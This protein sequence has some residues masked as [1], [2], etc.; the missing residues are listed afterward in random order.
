MSSKESTALIP[1][2]AL[3]VR[4]AGTSGDSAGSCICWSLLPYCNYVTFLPVDRLASRGREHEEGY[5]LCSL[6][7]PQNGQG[8]LDWGLG[9]FQIGEE[10]EGAQKNG[11]LSLTLFIYCV[12]LSAWD[13]RKRMRLR[14]IW[15]Q[16]SGANCLIGR[17]VLKGQV[18]PFIHQL[19]I[20]FLLIAEDPGV[21][22]EIGF[23]L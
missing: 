16:F 4:T 1:L 20:E 22:I 2:G 17:C 19:L 12:G 7:S 21:S 9:A 23:L 8:Q 6:C 11:W 13:T 18:K 10:L 5:G 15:V 3:W 14:E